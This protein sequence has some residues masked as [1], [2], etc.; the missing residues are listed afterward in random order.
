M[1]SSSEFGGAPEII[2]VSHQI[3]Y[4]RDV[5]PVVTLDWLRVISAYKRA[6]EKPKI[7]EKGFNIPHGQIRA[8]GAI[9][10]TELTHDKFDTRIFNIVNRLFGYE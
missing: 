6:Q 1:N 9:I 2:R 7:G 8:D 10:K 5:E 3:W 4:E